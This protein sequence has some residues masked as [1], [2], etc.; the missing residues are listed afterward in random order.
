MA[1]AMTNDI[2]GGAYGFEG[3]SG[4]MGTSYGIPSDGTPSDMDTATRIQAE[5]YD[6]YLNNKEAA[7]A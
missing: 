2:P 6:G 7:E 4:I 1:Y 5:S 3:K